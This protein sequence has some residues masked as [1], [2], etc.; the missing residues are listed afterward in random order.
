M[1]I[2]KLDPSLVVTSLKLRKDDKGTIVDLTLYKIL[3]GNS[4]YL[5]STS[6]NT[7]HDISHISRYMESLKDP[8]WK[9]RTMILRYE[10]GTKIYV[11]WYS[12]LD[13]FKLIRY[14]HLII[15][16]ISILEKKHSFMEI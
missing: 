7:I 13:E 15:V 9:E 6:P 14:V 5:T 1:I 10:S 3:L 12:R 4:M 2:Y 16:S 11:T 8:H